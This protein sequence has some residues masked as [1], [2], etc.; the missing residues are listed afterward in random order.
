MTVVT[1]ET[2]STV[3]ESGGACWEPALQQCP[4]GDFFR[5]PSTKC[6]C[7]RS[8]VQQHGPAHDKSS[9][10][11][12]QPCTL[13]QQNKKV[14]AWAANATNICMLGRFF[15]WLAMV[16]RTEERQPE[17]GS[18]FPLTLLFPTPLLYSQHY[19]R[20]KC[21]KSIVLFSALIRSSI[22]GHTGGDMCVREG[23]GGARGGEGNEREDR[24]YH[25]PHNTTTF[26]QDNLAVGLWQ[27]CLRLAGDAIGAILILEAIFH[28]AVPT[29]SSF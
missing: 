25:T 4:A 10:D 14:A 12:G 11:E 7:G 28:T 22:I 9:V 13:N 27:S 5:A 16:S 20:L 8:A 6:I 24:L 23:G 18:W 29:F 19:G 2:C 26:S 17:T 1:A 15:G 3:V 21:S